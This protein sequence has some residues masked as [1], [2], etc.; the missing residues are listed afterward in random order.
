MDLK[1]KKMLV[2]FLCALFFV[3]NISQLTGQTLTMDLSGEWGFSDRCNGFQ[4]GFVIT[5][6]QSQITGKNYTSRNNR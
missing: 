3:L 6:L 1:R 5:T 2:R 4:K